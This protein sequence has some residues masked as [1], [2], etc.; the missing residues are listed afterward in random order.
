MSHVIAGEDS[1]NET[2]SD[3]EQEYHNTPSAQTFT[4]LVPAQGIC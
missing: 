1:E 3:E 2:E 4:H